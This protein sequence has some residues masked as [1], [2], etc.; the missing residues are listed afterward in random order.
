MVGQFVESAFV[1][2]DGRGHRDCGD[3]EVP[4]V[5]AMAGVVAMSV[6]VTVGGGARWWSSMSIMEV[7][8][9]WRRD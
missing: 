2:I 8:R 4:S 1:E 5:G 3:G 6:S 7:M 9:R